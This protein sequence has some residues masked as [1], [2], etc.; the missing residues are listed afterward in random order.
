MRKNLSIRSRFHRLAF[1]WVTL[2]SLPRFRWVKI[3]SSPR[4]RWVNAALYPAVFTADGDMRQALNNLQATHSGFGYVN[5]E[6]VFK[7]CDQP[8]PQVISDCIAHCLQGNVDDAYDRIKFLY[9]AGFSAMDIIGTVYRVTKNFN[10]AGVCFIFKTFQVTSINLP[11]PVCLS[12]K[13]TAAIV[14]H[15]NTRKLALK[16]HFCNEKE[17]GAHPVYIRDDEKRHKTSVCRVCYLVIVC[18]RFKDS[19][20]RI[21]L[22]ISFVFCFVSSSLRPGGDARVRQT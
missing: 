20:S 5:Q 17:N 15:Y 8:H 9:Q 3:K 2:N 13:H 1:W 12:P 6:N 10:S 16:V 21:Q 7:V 19:E 11:R 18:S 14:V 4:F 22:V